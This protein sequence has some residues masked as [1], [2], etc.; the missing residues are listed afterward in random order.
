MR[1]GKT[2]ERWGKAIERWGKA[3]ER[4]IV[5]QVVLSL[6]M[7]VLIG[8]VVLWNMPA[9]RPRTAVGHVVDPIIQAVGLEQDWSLFAP[10]PRSFGVGVY[11]TVTYR[12]GRVKK[13]VTP[14]N[15]LFLSPYRTYRWQKFDERV[16]ADAYAGLWEPTAR[17]FAKKAG[18]DVVKVVLTRTF[19]EVTV[20]GDPTPRPPQQHHDFYALA[21][22]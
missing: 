14:H 12:D 7:V 1:W 11:A 6:F 19:R 13:L 8:A 3:I 18:G 15:G 4:S 20:P 21:L 5:G 10:N 16:R 2:V 9:G 22:P 17:W